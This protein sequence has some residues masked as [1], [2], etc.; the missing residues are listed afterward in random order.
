M[1]HLLVCAAFLITISLAEILTAQTV[2]IPYR[3]KD[4]WG[5]AD[6]TGKVRVKPKYDGILYGSKE[7]LRLPPNYYTIKKD[8]LIGISNGKEI[9]PPQF[10]RM[11]FFSHHIFVGIKNDN[12]VHTHLDLNGKPIVEAPLYLEQ[13]LWAFQYEQIRPDSQFVDRRF[14]FFIEVSNTVNK[15]KGVYLYHPDM[16]EKSRL[17]LNGYM[18]VNYRK[19]EE[20]QSILFKIQ[21]SRSDFEDNLFVFDPKTQD[22]KQELDLSKGKRN[23][24]EYYG[25]GDGGGY[26]RGGFGGGDVVVA[27]PPSE[28]KT[29]RSSFAMAFE[30][31][32]DSVLLY[33]KVS[34]FGKQNADSIP[35]LVKL[36]SDATEII[37]KGYN[38][39]YPLPIY[40]LE[41]IDYQ[42][43]N[44]ISFRSNGKMGIY[45]HPNQAPILHDTI[46]V[47]H[48][49][50][51][52]GDF[53]FFGD[54]DSKRVMLHGIKNFKDS[55]F[56]KPV[57]E[58]IYLNE[59][60]VHQIRTSI[61]EVIVKQNGK[62][63]I[64]NT[65]DKEL[66]S[67]KY[68]SIYTQKGAESSPSFRV[69]VKKDLYGICYSISSSKAPQIVEPFTKY[70]PF[71]LIWL[72]KN[73]PTLKPY[74]LINHYNPVTG[75]V[76]GVSDDKGIVYWRE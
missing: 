16:P 20:D 65:K 50:N 31:R 53:L 44:Y 24:R 55:V 46:S 57:Y 67:S 41:S 15:S 22:F 17:L 9:I 32:N 36:P 68:D 69:L 51:H 12:K 43:Q 19:E 47:I 5:F 2:L 54:Y 34:A 8:S 60:G 40:N 13:V 3:H 48:F 70:P 4:K 66:V 49:Y 14:I 75:K 39:R 25:E 37:I 56:I 28:R 74:F 21:I 76:M 45:V 62:Y 18:K 72:N 27:E 59:P 58:A 11:E 29:D 64:I 23:Q 30:I 42:Y 33:K 71:E 7:R 52:D 1:K 73:H 10:D 63:G 6:T 38:R 35:I 26:G 61:S